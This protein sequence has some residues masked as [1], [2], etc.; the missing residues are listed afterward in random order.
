MLSL[1]LPGPPDHVYS[2]KCNVLQPCDCLIK[3][4]R[5]HVDQIKWT[6]SLSCCGETMNVNCEHFDCFYKSINCI[7]QTLSILFLLETH[8]WLQS[9]SS[10]LHVTFDPECFATSVNT[11]GL[12]CKT[13]FPSLFSISILNSLQKQEV[14]RSNQKDQTSQ[15][16]HLSCLSA[17][18]HAHHPSWTALA[19]LW[20][21][22]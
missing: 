4:L 16:F 20:L 3:Y 6:V 15:P 9:C 7:F 17:P 10:V 14:A 12:D 5:E 8:T 19:Q 2:P 11:S 1:N 21:L 18:V 13:A 22:P